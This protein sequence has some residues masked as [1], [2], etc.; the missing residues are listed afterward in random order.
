MSSSL[1]LDSSSF[2]DLDAE[3]MYMHMADEE[4]AGA[5]MGMGME[6]DAEAD[7]T[8]TSS[9]LRA[10]NAPSRHLDPS[11][12]LAATLLPH[13]RWLCTA[14]AIPLPSSDADAEGATPPSSSTPSIDVSSALA[15]V[16]NLE[17]TVLSQQTATSSSLSSV[18]SV[19]LHGEAGMRRGRDE[20]AEGENVGESGSASSPSLASASQISGSSSG[21]NGGSTR[22]GVP[23]VIGILRTLLQTAQEGVDSVRGA[24]MSLLLSVSQHAAIH[25]RSHLSSLVSLS[26][27]VVRGDKTGRHREKALELLG[28]LLMLAHTHNVDLTQQREYSPPHVI[29]AQLFAQINVSKS[30]L[31]QSMKGHLLSTLGLLSELCEEEFRRHID[32]ARSLADLYG[33]SLIDEMEGSKD[34]HRK[35]I[36][37]C[38]I[39]LKHFLLSFNDQFRIGHQL[40]VKRLEQLWKAVR[41]SIATQDTNRYDILRAG[42]A[43]FCRHAPLWRPFMTGEV[44]T[45]MTAKS[46]GGMGRSSEAEVLLDLLLRA[47]K[48]PNISVSTRAAAA[49]D[50]YL[51]QIAAFLIEAE[52]VKKTAAGDAASLASSS[53]S[54]SN[55][56]SPAYKRRLFNL[57]LSVFAKKIDPTKGVTEVS[58][59]VRALGQLARVIKLYLSEHELRRLLGRL[60]ESSDKLFRSPTP[61][62]LDRA[63]AHMPD[64]MTASAFIIQQ[65]TSCDSTVLN[66]LIQLVRRCF[67]AYPTLTSSQRSKNLLALTRLFV[68]LYD[69][70]LVFQQLLESV[71]YPG[72]ILTIS[73]L[74]P[75][76]DVQFF[77]QGRPNLTQRHAY[78]EYTYLWHN[79]L[80]VTVRQD[81]KGDKSVLMWNQ[82]LDYPDESIVWGMRRRM[83]D[84]LMSDV[85]KILT[86][87]DMT[88]QSNEASESNN[89][90]TDD[91]DDMS[92]TDRSERVTHGDPGSALTPSKPKDVELFLNL[93]EFIQRFFFPPYGSTTTPTGGPSA[94][95]Q[96]ILLSHHKYASAHLSDRVLPAA[97][98]LN[99][100]VRLSFLSRWFLSWVAL[101]VPDL[102]QL[103][104]KH[105]L[106]SG[107][108]KII[109]AV[110]QIMQLYEYMDGIELNGDTG[111][112]SIE[113]VKSQGDEKVAEGEVRVKSE[114]AV[115]MEDADAAASSLSS[116]TNIGPPSSHHRLPL[117]TSSNR[118]YVFNLLSAYLHGVLVR[119]PQLSDELLYAALNLLLTAPLQ[120]VRLK[121][122][123]PALIR[124]ID[125]GRSYRPAAYLSINTLKRWMDA[126]REMG[127]TAK[128]EKTSIGTTSVQAVGKRQHVTSAELPT[129]YPQILPHFFDYLRLPKA[130]SSATLHVAQS[131]KNRGGSSSAAPLATVDMAELDLITRILEFLGSIGGHNR[132]ILGDSAERESSDVSTASAPASDTSKDGNAAPAW[133]ATSSIRYA[134]PLSKK[135]DVL[136]DPLLPHLAHLAESATDRQVQVAACEALHALI[137]Y[138]ISCTA[139]DPNRTRGSAEAGQQVVD[140]SAFLPL[141]QHLFPILLRLAT[142]T[143]SVCKQLFHPLTFQIIHWFTNSNTTLYKDTR[144][145]LDAVTDAVGNEASGA[146]REYAADCMAEFFAWSIKHAHVTAG[147]G[148]KA[149]AASAEEKSSSATAPPSAPGSAMNIK[150]LLRRLYSLALHPSPYKRLGAALTLNRLYRTFREHDTLV[151][152]HTLDLLDHFL[153]SLRLAESDE[154]ALGTRDEIR[155]VIDALD[156]IVTD[157]N[158]RKYIQLQ[159]QM[160]RAGS[161]HCQSLHLFTAALLQAAGSVEDAYR[162]ECLRLFQSFCRVLV[163]K[164]HGGD[165][166]ASFIRNFSHENGM[167]KLVLLIE[168][169][170]TDAQG[171]VA[172]A[173]MQ[174]QGGT[175]AAAPDNTTLSTNPIVTPDWVKSLL[176]GGADSLSMDESEDM[177]PSQGTATSASVSPVLQWSSLQIWL[178]R[179]SSSLDVYW[180]L[181][182]ERL[183]ADDVRAAADELWRAD[184]E[185]YLTDTLKDIIMCVGSV[186][187]EEDAAPTRPRL[188]V[189]V[190]AHAKR[191]A[192]D[193]AAQKLRDMYRNIKCTLLIRLFRLM[194]LLLSSSKADD[195][196]SALSSRSRSRSGVSGPALASSL[197]GSGF[198]SL[199]LDCLLRPESAGFSMSQSKRIRV[200]QSTIGQLCSALLDISGNANSF[201]KQTQIVLSQKDLAPSSFSVTSLLHRVGF[202]GLLVEGYRQLWSSGLLQRALGEDACNEFAQSL[203]QQAFDLYVNPHDQ[204]REQRRATSRPLGRSVA[205]QMLQLALHIGIPQEDLLTMLNESDQAAI[206]SK[207]ESNSVD[208]VSSGSSSLSPVVKQEAMDMDEEKKGSDPQPVHSSGA[209]KGQV[210]YSTYRTLIDS[211]IATQ[212][213]SFATN[214]LPMAMESKDMMTLLLNVADHVII[215]RQR[216]KIGQHAFRSDVTAGGKTGNAASSS[217]SSIE[218]S[219]MEAD[220]FVTHVLDNLPSACESHIRARTALINAPSTAGSTAG[221]GRKMSAARRR[222]AMQSQTAPKDSGKV[223]QL[224]GE[225]E[226][227]ARLLRLMEQLIILDESRVLSPH[228]PTFSTL[229]DIYQ[230]CISDDATITLKRTALS[231]LPT[232]FL[233]SSAS[234]STTAM[235]DSSSSSSSSAASKTQPLLDVPPA[236]SPLTST[237]RHLVVSPPFPHHSRDVA[238]GSREYVNYTS[239][240]DPLL[241]AL[242]ISKHFTLI[243]IMLPILREGDDHVYSA[244]INTAIA[245]YIHN[246]IDSALGERA[247]QVE[248]T[249]QR[250]LD[251]FLQTDLDINPHHN[252]RYWLAHHIAVPALRLC[253][254][255]AVRS[256]FKSNA[257]RLF[258][259]V[260]SMPDGPRAAV[261]MEEQQLQLMEMETAYIILA[262]MYQRLTKEECATN[263][264]HKSL[265]KLSHAHVKRV[266]NPHPD[267][268]SYESFYGAAYTCLSSALKLT[269]SVPKFFDVLC[270]SETPAKGELLWSHIID[271]NKRTLRFEIETNFKQVEADLADLRT[272]V[273]QSQN[274]SGGS[275]ATGGSGAGG[276]AVASSA[277]YLSSRYLSDSSLSQDVQGIWDSEGGAAGHLLQKQEEQDEAESKEDETLA[278]LPEDAS[279]PPP[280]VVELVD[281][282]PILSIPAMPSLLS[283]ISHMDS[284]FGAAHRDATS[285]TDSIRMPEWMSQMYSQMCSSST[286]ITIKWCIAKCIVLKHTVF[287]PYASLWF[288]PLVQLMTLPA[289]QNGGIG[290]HYFLRDLCSVFLRWRFVPGPDEPDREHASMLIAHLMTVAADYGQVTEG[291][292]A[293]LRA[294]LILIRMLV[295]LWQH[296][297]VI[298]RSIILALLRR[299]VSR[300]RAGSDALTGRQIGLQLLAII[301]DRGFPGFDALEDVG[302]KEGDMLAAVMDCIH[303]TKKTL[304]EPAAEVMGIWIRS[305]A[306]SQRDPEQRRIHGACLHAVRQ[307][308]KKLFFQRE[309][310]PFL[311]VL[312]KLCLHLARLDFLDEEMQNLVF[313]LPQ[314]HGEQ[315]HLFLR[316][317]ACCSVANSTQ[318]YTRL[319]P[320]IRRVLASVDSKA[321]ELMLHCIFRILT[322]MS[323]AELREL[324]PE[325]ESLCTNHQSDACRMLYYKCLI[326]IYDNHPDFQRGKQAFIH[327]SQ[328]QAHMEEMDSDSFGS[329]SMT[330]GDS[331]ARLVMVSLLRGLSDS[332]SDIRN[333][334]FNFWDDSSRLSADVTER[335]LQVLTVCFQ[336][337]TAEHWLATATRLII[338]PMRKS[339]DYDRPFSNTAL[340]A[341]AFEPMYVN[342][343]GYTR[344]QPMV[345]LFSG[346]TQTQSSLDEQARNGDVP[347]EDA[348][349]AGAVGGG[350]APGF[351]FVLNSQAAPLAFNPTPSLMSLTTQELLDYNLSQTTQGEHLFFRAP[352]GASQALAGSYQAFSAL[353]QQRAFRRRLKGR[354]GADRGRVSIKSAHRVQ[355]GGDSIALRFASSLGARNSLSN[356]FRTQADLRNRYQRVWAERMQE[357]AVASVTIY[358]QYRAGELP[359]IQIAHKEM[360]LPLEALHTQPAIAQ[361]IFIAV[362]QAIYAQ[363]QQWEPGD[364]VERYRSTVRDTI[365]SLFHRLAS[366]ATPPSSSLVSGLAGAVVACGRLDPSFTS[367]WSAG[368][369]KKIGDVCLL[370]HNL[371]SGII[372]LE[373]ILATNSASARSSGRGARKRSREQQEG[374]DR[375]EQAMYQ[376]ARLYRELGENEIMMT[377]YASFAHQD[378]T[379][380]A[381]NAMVS[382][383]YSRAMTLYD[384]ALTR[385]DAV[386]NGESDWDGRAPTADE[387]ELWSDERMECMRQLTEWQTLR[388]NVLVEVDGEPERLWMDEYRKKGDYLRHYFTSSLKVS[389]RA[390]LQIAHQA[391]VEKSSH[392]PPLASPP[393]SCSSSS[394]F[395]DPRS[396]LFSFVDRAFA[397]PDRSRVLQGEY[398]AELVLLYALRGHLPQAITF[399]CHTYIRFLQQWSDMPAGAA[400][401]RYAMLQGLQ[402]LTEAAE[403]LHAEEEMAREENNVKK[404]ASAAARK[405]STDSSAVSPIVSLSTRL[406]RQMNVWR[407]RLPSRTADVES[408]DDVVL[409]RSA[410]LVHLQQRLEGAANM[411]HPSQQPLC[412]PALLSV[413]T[414]LSDAVADMH[415]EAARAMLRQGNVS[416]ADKY[417]TDSKRLLQA[418]GIMNTAMTAEAAT[419]ADMMLHSAQLEF[420]HAYTSI[421]IKLKHLEQQHDHTSSI[422][423][424]ASATHASRARLTKSLHH[425]LTSTWSAS[426]R[427]QKRCTSTATSMDPADS[428]RV[429]MLKCRLH[430]MLSEQII[431]EP[432][433]SKY[434]ED[435]GANEWLNESNDELTL[436]AQKWMKRME[437]NGWDGEHELATN[438]QTTRDYNLAAKSFMAVANFAEQRLSQ[439][440]DH[441]ESCST[442]KAQAACSH[443]L[444]LPAELRIHLIESF[445][446]NVLAAMKLGTYDARM[447]FP[448]ALELLGSTDPNSPIRAHFRSVTKSIPVWMFLDWLPQLL[449]TLGLPHGTLIHS[450]LIRMAKEYPQA[451]IYPYQLTRDTLVSSRAPIKLQEPI[452]SQAKHALTHMRPHLDNKLISWFIESLDY[453]NPPEFKLRDTLRV[454]ERHVRNG[455]V[456][457]AKLEWQKF[458]TAH[459][460]SNA[461]IVAKQIGS[462][463]Q[464]LATS[465]KASCDRAF[466]SDGSKLLKMSHAAMAQITK[467]L[468][469][470]LQERAGKRKAGKETMATYTSWPL[471][472]EKWAA[473]RHEWIELPGQ[474]NGRQRPQPE[475]HVRIV[476]F[477][478][479]VLTMSSLR[480]PK[481]IT[482]H[483]SDEKS[484]HYLV[485]GGEDLRM[486]QRVEQT[487]NTINQILS[488]D[489]AASRRGL[490]LRTYEVVPFTSTLGMVEWVDNTEPLKSLVLGQLPNA[491][492]IVNSIT[493]KYSEEMLKQYKQTKQGG[494]VKANQPP[495]YYSYIKHASTKH[496]VDFFTR[497][498]SN[499]PRDLVSSFIWRLSPSPS[500]Y[501]ASRSL[502]SRS[503]CALSMSAYILGIG[504]RHLENFLIDRN[505]CQVVGID[506]GAAF[507]QGPLLSVPE[508]MPFRY[509]RL[510]RNTY[511][512]LDTQLIQKQDMTKVMKAIRMS[513]RK[514]LTVMDVFIKEPMMEWVTAAKGAYR[515]VGGAKDDIL[516]DDD[517]MLG[518][519]PDPASIVAWYP[520][521]K[522]AV[523]KMKLNGANPA[524]ILASELRENVK[525]SGD[526]VLYDRCT[527]V[528]R[529]DDPAARRAQFDV[530]SHPEEQV[531]LLCDIAADPNILG[532]TWVGWGPFF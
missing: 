78:I 245:T 316:V 107:L 5:A 389:E 94:S 504:D 7:T 425:L 140:E 231:L 436:M 467:P 427:L 426:H 160:E 25:L 91:Q 418:H 51:Q 447:L 437:E 275:T 98:S 194:H 229:L 452:L 480:K 434:A 33:R 219:R 196:S 478:P 269:Q 87:L 67:L 101:F 105:P 190:D 402:K 470:A 234:M 74:P 334:L 435:K 409:N 332:S 431:A 485:K 13:L 375:Q 161:S 442:C 357:E 20:S 469:A 372:M 243:D 215:R 390:F 359:D 75:L 287:Q 264:D 235:T 497:L 473:Q 19:L 438:V 414:T 476:N 254:L 99:S 89:G 154:D 525:V 159:R 400:G 205:H 311:Q 225:S 71:V 251:M 104:N 384:E 40:K 37:G 507:G 481:R 512:P 80:G 115:K 336:P 510:L 369:I 391:A 411:M 30:K 24:I 308:L 392:S 439:A 163:S 135:L 90:Q 301:L 351:G 180:W 290:F 444:V 265:V 56:H 48:H 526:A 352:G 247:G 522:M 57:L 137:I 320:T 500:A 149:A 491:V 428:Y 49:L 112:I 257:S 327:A 96:R 401:P 178:S 76:T 479:I 17:Q 127:L 95:S 12:G 217:M 523:V 133:S 360:L 499:I 408:W 433:L 282:D 353:P 221:A 32:H 362:V 209:S 70:G 482:I 22:R 309:Y 344:T 125:I 530:M 518:R 63:V 81:E 416:V 449:G 14:L 191:Q 440:E 65:L 246:L 86:T 281:L 303:S 187:L 501:L 52:S 489:P 176:S 305:L 313:Q 168:Q 119:L 88:L 263:V 310:A 405:Y 233:V 169:G 268:L 413:R 117:D 457:E 211:Y 326:W 199:L 145:L 224:P 175:D 343:S 227:A 165:N 9:R 102:I 256:F 26:L 395:V 494:D 132:F 341:V 46:E 509:T 297:L 198:Y 492:N 85:R 273:T 103:S 35:V 164:S 394:S 412:R 319:R 218:Q 138:M 166:G 397:H 429:A 461:S 295:D 2:L 172:G 23:G 39:G 513:K 29:I 141:Y 58:V 55:A 158:A 475:L 43:C 284:Q 244:Q 147:R 272:L 226:L 173:G 186:R 456:D 31:S 258:K 462:A 463:Y 248:A 83:F 240:L 116:P 148:A 206:S 232:F 200:L 201:I 496:V 419:D 448:R 183:I 374:E 420:M 129:Y 152:F 371:H 97:L 493:V 230:Q 454:I 193:E 277:R 34:P 355:L 38:L 424:S 139:H 118:R 331:L 250:C 486:D 383:D 278:L 506:F 396:E 267:Q 503:F 382:G 108:Y 156:R 202:A 403:F 109:A 294:N 460:S 47:C 458:R 443:P 483:G 144:A 130:D 286:H 27:Y 123:V 100:N 324:M 266:S 312:L 182:K 106:I 184:T 289:D 315:Q 195:T 185:S 519:R 3:Q 515:T 487:F 72:L 61:D 216:K 238:V 508:L 110:S 77:A 66:S 445:V 42:L 44:Q 488:N 321:H 339:A 430:Q 293:R 459:F 151:S 73:A 337:E 170:V 322:V 387:I 474:Y 531:Q 298:K 236:L 128:Q 136:L 93:V 134:F 8:T 348:D 10:S 477:D 62:E 167:S 171:A 329:S 283:L 366:S 328:S 262:I 192:N 177:K 239:L 207:P 302:L 345:P 41:L 421:N 157:A 296:R 155:A 380:N 122:W 203:L 423:D 255:P 92:E 300:A 242:H 468:Y 11:L 60:L 340:A 18:V 146:L 505:S 53:S 361:E 318:L 280:A 490:S 517:T 114:F 82:G 276:S 465:Y 516:I 325:L 399:L 432:G 181:L 393:S 292:R 142:H 237:L 368:D 271:V 379:R 249:V 455:Q 291:K 259:L 398:A 367:S 386:Q 365:R 373:H 270:F 464:E 377:L 174:T 162:R 64:F 285:D 330:G 422:G 453:L 511:T 524:K 527:Q 347:M 446:K 16:A 407:A 223:L 349:V 143:E 381:I 528:L 376:L 111:S 204:T 222:N 59:G 260:E 388:E 214:L 472:F 21:G 364:K 370:S 228:Q 307:S 335:L 288:M 333:H 450:L 346:A 241:A 495:V 210:F 213:H 124:S 498:E 208:I 131:G 338:Y 79:L 306:G 441:V 212:F 113:E 520:R 410:F 350:A 532:R 253:P 126:D 317:L 356:R 471:Q 28:F 385:F 188:D 150:S 50:A 466:G 451:V 54:S 68:V 15:A 304:Y 314:L 189:W 120:M 417:V 220:A 514:L 358:R 363:I 279:S 354:K 197:L 1:L 529:G 323:G 404:G 4:E 179:V 484:H 415:R 6:E 406:Q 261:S 84:Q 252:V 378:S 69:K 45:E 153:H 299:D 521:R 342:S 502:F 274:G 121:D 36:E